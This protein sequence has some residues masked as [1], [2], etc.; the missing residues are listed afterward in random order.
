M[1]KIESARI[2]DAVLITG[3]IKLP[4]TKQGDIEVMCTSSGDGIYSIHN[5][6]CNGMPVQRNT[7][8]F[9]KCEDH[10]AEFA[11]AITKA[12]L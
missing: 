10:M 2:V 6:S 4:N 12:V 7:W 11:E 5:V 1:I 9:N 8:I 3:S